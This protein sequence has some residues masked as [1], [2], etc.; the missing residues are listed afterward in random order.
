MVN[1]L[2][3]WLRGIVIAVIISTIIEMI[4]PNGNIKKYIKT[5]M[6]V[7]LIFVIISPI[8]SKIT[9]KEIDILKY[10][11]S[12]TK[13]YEQKEIATI[14][15]NTYIEQIYKEN[16]KQDI[17]KNLEEKGYKIKKIEAEIETEEIDYGKI[18]KLK[19]GIVKEN[20]N[21]EPVEISVNK[22]DKT[23]EENISQ[24]EVLNIKTFLETT[25]GVNQKDIIIN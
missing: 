16:I 11:N 19:I 9:G 22:E 24:E 8:I 15:T 1:W 21:I 6:G 5:V 2:N 25:Y 10:I 20:K 14:D 13:K 3:S 17:T 4:I 18:K 7:Y 23:K 12:Q